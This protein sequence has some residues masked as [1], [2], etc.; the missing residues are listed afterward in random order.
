MYAALWLLLSCVFA[1]QLFLSGYVTP[2]S[3]AFAGELV[4]WLSW[5]AML[6]FVFWWCRR[7]RERSFAV[8]VTGLVFAAFI[9][10]LLAPL[11]AHTIVSGLVSTG[12]CGGDCGLGAQLLSW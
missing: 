3:R 1:S 12:L 10:A 4:Y 7:L 8:R 2:W 6:P 5:G 9:T 11:I